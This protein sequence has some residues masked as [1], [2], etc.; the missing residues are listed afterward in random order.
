MCSSFSSR[1]VEQ[2]TA[3]LHGGTVP[4][5]SSPL[6]DEPRMSSHATDLPASLKNDTARF[7]YGD[8]LAMTHWR[9][10]CNDGEGW[11]FD[12]C[13]PPFLTGISPTLYLIR[14]QRGAPFSKAIFSE[15]AGNNMLLHLFQGETSI[16]IY[17]FGTSC[18]VRDINTAISNTMPHL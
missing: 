14:S 15:N 9:F 3:R 13:F 10:G 18:P 7:I 6:F 2:K 16:S 17:R 11:F 4:S 1:C 8:G 5:C 12:L